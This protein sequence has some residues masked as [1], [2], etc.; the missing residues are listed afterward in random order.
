VILGFCVQV[1]MG[2]AFSM[3]A[4][5]STQARNVYSLWIGAG[6]FLSG[7]I[8]P[9][10]LFPEAIRRLASWLPFR[11][12]LGLP[13]EI[14]MGR[15]TTSDTLFG[16]AVAAAWIVAFMVIYRLLWLRGLRRYEAVGG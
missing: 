15:L 1:A 4:F 5:W 3:I 7:W 12:T 13:V 10:A 9:L 2:A 6:Q 16:L 11:A 14:L 8:V